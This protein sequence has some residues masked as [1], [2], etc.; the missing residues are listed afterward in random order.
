MVLEAGS[1]EAGHPGHMGPGLDHRQGPASS[2][3]Q[4]CTYLL[5]RLGRS[6]LWLHLRFGP[7]RA[8]RGQPCPTP[9]WQKGQGAT[10]SP[11]GSRPGRGEEPR[12][13]EAH[14]H[15]RTQGPRWGWSQALGAADRSLRSQFR[16]RRQRPVLRLQFHR[17]RGRG[18]AGWRAEPWGRAQAQVQGQL[19]SLLGR[20]GLPGT[21]GQPSSRAPTLSGPA[22]ISQIG[23]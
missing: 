20:Q 23:N 17:A 10:P 5:L 6:S 1:S 12:R 14:G 13:P 3:W 11:G 22:S 15:N 4:A 18:R 21:L 9:S 7:G 19:S 8:V 2:R 16:V